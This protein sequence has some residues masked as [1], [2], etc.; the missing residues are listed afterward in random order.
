MVHFERQISNVENFTQVIRTDSTMLKEAGNL[1][2]RVKHNLRFMSDFYESKK[3]AD[4]FEPIET[5]FEKLN[6]LE[7][8]NAY[9]IEKVNALSAD[10]K[11]SK[12]NEEKYKSKLENSEME[13]E[14]KEWENKR[15]YG[16][17]EIKHQTKKK[18]QSKKPTAVKITEI[19]DGDVQGKGNERKKYAESWVTNTEKYKVEIDPE[20]SRIDREKKSTN[21]PIPE[22]DRSAQLDISKPESTKR[23]YKQLMSDK[24]AEST[25]RDYKQKMLDKLNNI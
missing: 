9:L 4:W 8:E 17:K 2:P 15:V 3:F 20:I 6:R 16:S 10:L 11:E 5:Y 14:I 23:D 7:L 12:E 18:V 24:L 13:K 19:Q 22:P 1:T 25:K 21:E